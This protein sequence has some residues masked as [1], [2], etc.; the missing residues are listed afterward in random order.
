MSLT[1][2]EI[3]EIRVPEVITEIP[4][5]RLDNLIELASE[6]TGLNYGSCRENA[7]A[8]RVLHWITK[9][10]LNGGNSDGTNSGNG[11]AG[12]ITSMSEG[13]LSIAYSSTSKSSNNND[14][15]ASTQYGV[16]LMALADGCIFLQ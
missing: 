14:D 9:S 15:L 13:G 11:S 4:S 10:K 5:E 1:A 2:I 3:I 8:L 16:E 6:Q 12:Q 7:I